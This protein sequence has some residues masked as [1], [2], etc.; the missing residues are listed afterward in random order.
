[1]ILLFLL[2]TT[3]CSSPQATESMYRFRPLSDQELM[4]RTAGLVLPE[5]AKE[6]A[7]FSNLDNYG[8]YAAA[9]RGSLLRLFGEPLHIS[10]AQYDYI[11][12]ASDSANHVWI[13]TAY[14]G[15]SGPGFGGDTSDQSIY[16]VATD[17][18]DLIE[19]T[20]PADFEDVFYSDEYDSTVTYGCRD[21]ACYYQEEHGN[22][23]H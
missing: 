20:P 13:L 16:P 12:E 7:A 5:S 11:I 1:M 19:R 3:A 4:W 9:F 15:D 21:G 23:L 10:D 14:E 6:K 18:R 8:P 17:L 2:T 22:H